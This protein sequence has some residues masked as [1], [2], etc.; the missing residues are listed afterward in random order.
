MPFS[1]EAVGELRSIIDQSIV[2]SGDAVASTVPGTTFVV[3][4]RE[5]TELFAQS[6]GKRGIKSQD[7]MTLDSV[8]WMASCTK[9]VVGLA[10]MQLVE[11]GPLNLD[12]AAQVEGLCP[13]LRDVKVLKDDGTFDEKKRGITLRM[14]LSHTSGFGYTFFDET[15]RDWSHPI[16]IDEFSGDIK[17]ILKIPLRFQ[18]GEGWKYGIGVDWAGIVLERKTGTSLNDYIQK[19]ICQPL[20]LENVNMLPT[21]AMKDKLAYMHQRVQDGKLIPRDHLLRRPL[22]VSTPEEIAGLFH[23]GGAG[24]FAK[25]Q[26]YARILTV[27]LND[28]TCPKTG[29]K[30]VEKS[31][32]DEMFTNQI[33][34]FPDHGRQGVPAAKPDL[35]NPLP[36]LYH[37][38]GNPPQ[39]WGLTFMLS[40]ASPL[41]GRSDKTGHWAGLPNNYW[42]CDREHGVAG[43]ICSQILPFLDAGVVGL[44]FKLEAAVYRHLEASRR[45]DTELSRETES[46]SL[47]S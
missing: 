9:M 40:N 44:W 21:Q 12:D 45:G 43:L 25:P 16:G 10:C 36:D 28:G 34:Q 7:H 29:A 2:T 33:P 37:V 3:V 31:T 27:L 39:G 41:T 24:L 26:E 19:N 18:P 46:L 5:G 32:V 8:F 22:V 38:P 11:K 42:W 6:A 23:S 4:D 20:G 17:D 1:E 14:L 30:L 35:T 15:L 47:K 13:E